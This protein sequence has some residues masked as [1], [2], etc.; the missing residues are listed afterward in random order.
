MMDTAIW[1]IF[2]GLGSRE[3]GGLSGEQGG[4]QS[5][6]VDRLKKTKPNWVRGR[7][8]RS[9]ERA[10]RGYSKSTEYSMNIETN[11]G[12]SPERLHSFEPPS[13]NPC[14]NDCEPTKLKLKLYQGLRFDNLE[15]EYGVHRAS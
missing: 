11:I 14:P 1:R 7:R 4:K 12:L 15:V 10:K 6:K 9:P 2:G 5:G 8:D 3:N 13:E